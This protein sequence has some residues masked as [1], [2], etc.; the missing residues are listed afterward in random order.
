MIDKRVLGDRIRQ[1]RLK[2]GVSQGDLGKELGKTHAAI[3]D[4]ELGKS[5]LSVTDLS[6]IANYFQI[7]V[8]ELIENM[9]QP[10]FIHNRDTKGITPEEKKLA[11]QATEAVMKL[12]REMAKKKNEESK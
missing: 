6:K 4:I 12:A 11:D 9:Q 1:F 2:K 5:E 7:M 8:T 10:S 3:S